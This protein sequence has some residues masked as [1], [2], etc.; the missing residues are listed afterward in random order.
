LFSVAAGIVKFSSKKLKKFNGQL[1]Q[2]TVVNV[3]SEK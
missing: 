1:R 2:T 3:V